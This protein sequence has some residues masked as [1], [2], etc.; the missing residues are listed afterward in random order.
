MK[1]AYEEDRSNESLAA[2]I[3]QLDQRLNRIR[4]EKMDFMKKSGWFLL[5]CLTL[6]LGCLKARQM[7]TAEINKPSSAS[8]RQ[9]EQQ[10]EAA[11]GR[12]AVTVAL[13]VLL[14][15]WSVMLAWQ[16]RTTTPDALQEPVADGRTET[17]SQTPAPV[18][19]DFP[20][21]DEVCGNWPAFRGA[22]GSGIYI[23]GEIPAAFNIETGENILWKTPLNSLPGKNSPVIW[24]D[25]IFI[26]G[27]DGQKQEIYSFDLNSGTLQW[28]ASIPLLASEEIDVMED[29][30]YSAC[31]MVTDGRRV[32]AIFA[33]GDIGAVDMEGRLV[34]NRNLGVPDSAYGYASSLAMYED[35]ILVQYDQG[36]DPEEG[37]SQMIALE[38]AT[39]KTAWETVRPVRASWTSPV[40]AK[41]DNKYVLLT[42]AEPF[43][44]AYNPADGSELWRAECISGD[45]APSPVVGNDAVIGIEVYYRAVAVKPGQGVLDET[46]VVTV[47]EDELP[48]IPSPLARDEVLWITSTEGVL[49]CWTLKGLFDDLAE[50][51]E[52]RQLWLH[53]F[54][55]QAFN[56]SPSLAGDMLIFVT[57]KGHVIT[58]KATTEAYQELGH[59]QLNDQVDA[60]PAFARGKMIIRGTEYLWCIGKQP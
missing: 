19:D 46:H 15:A 38:A 51:V 30:G 22:D 54:E 1:K 12:R 24:G 31:S 41:M 44:I 48:D 45:A 35:K 27:S 29:T 9:A 55:G 32:Y 47:A 53:E 43:I 5:G 52:S 36:Y 6:S 20:A 11:I 33:M 14:V 50:P 37:I 42:C 57:I 13:G 60:S 34:W 28:T 7:L 3:R 2:S 39:G 23:E 58:A 4:F 16:S 8:D 49:T 59:S 40:V 26:C 25:Q 17:K 10:Q 56:A 18:K 21:M